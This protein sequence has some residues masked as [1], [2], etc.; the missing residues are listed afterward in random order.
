M[1]NA[2]GFFAGIVSGCTKL[3]VGHPFETVKVRCQIDPTTKPLKCLVDTVKK[4]G[5]RALYKGASPPLFGWALMDSVQMGTLTNLRLFLD[6]GSGLTLTDHA[7]AGLG[8]GLVVPFVAT[9]IEVLK[10]NLQIQKD[11]SVF[12]GPLDCFKKLVRENGIRGI[13][14]G[15]DGCLLFRSFFW[16]LWGSYEVYKNQLEK[17]GMHSSVP[18]IAGGLA[19]NTFWTISFPADVMKNK[20]MTRRNDD[21]FRNIPTCFN[22]IYKTEGIKG[23]YRGFIPCLIRSFPT[24]GAAILA[25]DCVLK[26]SILQ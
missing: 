10:G 17:W 7:L 4:E 5:F 13:Y 22:Y 24:N 6:N 25:F 11:K 2:I 15:L 1:E 20:L 19:A 21:L 18:F 3:L 23:F 14:K 16:V 12:T 8:A 26:Y 9:P